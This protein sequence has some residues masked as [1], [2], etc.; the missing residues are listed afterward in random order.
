MCVCVCVC[1]CVV[2]YCFLLIKYCPSLHFGDKIYLL[3]FP[4]SINWWVSIADVD[5]IHS[6]TIDTTATSFVTN[7]ETTN[8]R[9]VTSYPSE[10]TGKNQNTSPD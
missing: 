3:I 1:V 5:T 8:M 9:D 10:S 2:F 4:R 6:D 7:L